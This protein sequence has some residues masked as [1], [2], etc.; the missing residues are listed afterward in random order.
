MHH[1]DFPSNPVVKTVLPLQGMWVQSLVGELRS[2]MLCS[3]A[4]R[5]KKKRHHG[6]G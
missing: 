6:F 3:T 1:E 5:L 4:K 2:Y